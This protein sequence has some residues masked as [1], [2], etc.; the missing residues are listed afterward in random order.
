[1]KFSKKTLL[2]CLISYLILIF[3]N[4][5]EGQNAVIIVDKSNISSQKVYGSY[6]YMMLGLNSSSFNNLY[7]IKLP[8]GKPEPLD[9]LIYRG[10]SV[11]MSDSGVFY[12][13]FKYDLDGNNGRH[14]LNFFSFSKNE[15]IFSKEINLFIKSPTQSYPSLAR[16][17]NNK[18]YI[19]G[20]YNSK[21]CIWESNGTETGTKIIFSDNSSIKNYVFHF[22]KIAVSTDN[23]WLN[24][25]NKLMFSKNGIGFYYTTKNVSILYNSKSNN[26]KLWLMNHLGEIDSVSMNF[27]YISPNF[28]MV[29]ES[30]SMITWCS[31]VGDQMYTYNLRFVP[32]FRYDSIPPSNDLQLLEYYSVDQVYNSP[33]QVN[34][35]FLSCWSMKYGREMAFV[36]L[37][38]SFRL[39]RDLK[40]GFGSGVN[41]INWSNLILSHKNVT[42]FLG[43]NGADKKTYVY[44]SDGKGMKSHFSV[45]NLNYNFQPL[46]IY[47]SF[48]FWSSFK[49]DTLYICHRNLTGKDTQPPVKI[50]GNH[51]EKNGEWLRTAA[52][53]SS[54]RQFSQMNSQRVY[55][56]LAKSDKH[57]N[58]YL[59][60]SYPYHVERNNFYMLFS[61]TNFIQTVYGDRLIVKYDSTGKLLWS[62][63]FGNYS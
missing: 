29:N 62:L 2:S 33:N 3:S 5:L 51:D 38:D 26:S 24:E 21:N 31:M 61:D 48:L 49:N 27:K 25:K 36:S 20:Y 10:Q 23:G 7:R 30:D 41:T 6:L 1:M 58:V 57:G 34:K 17:I 39:I 52:P 43:S 59:C 4:S 37:H 44:S 63:S 12:V 42:Y 11:L 56:N 40:P 60:G 47:D 28:K 45:G 18:F 14:I 46:C 15:K 13:S 54:V 19:S 16:L 53:V 22:D 35:Q 55:S 9:T 8:N 32:P 50:H